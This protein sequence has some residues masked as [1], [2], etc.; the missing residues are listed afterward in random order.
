M[1]SVAAKLSPRRL[2]YV[3]TLKE[4][5]VWRQL[6][7]L[8]PTSQEASDYRQSAYPNVDNWVISRVT[9]HET[10]QVKSGIGNKGRRPYAIK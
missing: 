1:S 9:G 8:F 3:L 5:N 2:G 7:M 10:T 4:E 6:E